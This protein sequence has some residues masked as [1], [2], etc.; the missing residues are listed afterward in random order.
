MRISDLIPNKAALITRNYWRKRN[1]LGQPG[2]D[3][4]N[5]Q[6]DTE[7]ALGARGD[8][9]GGS[10]L[11]QHGWQDDDAVHVLLFPGGRMIQG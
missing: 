10:D 8:T 6:T 7:G 5:N 3:Y 2:A 11:Q 9:A 1:L 4:I